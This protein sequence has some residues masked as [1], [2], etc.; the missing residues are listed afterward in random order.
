MTPNPTGPPTRDEFAA[1]LIKRLHQAGETRELRYDEA[2]FQLIYLE[3]GQV[4][5]RQRLVRMFDELHRTPIGERKDWWTSTVA[6]LQRIAD[7]LA[8]KHDKLLTELRPSIRPRSYFDNLVI[9]ADTDGLVGPAVPYLRQRAAGA[10][11]LFPTWFGNPR[12]RGGCRAR[13]TTSTSSSSVLDR[14]GVSRSCSRCQRSVHPAAVPAS[15]GS[16]A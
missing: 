1:F 4:V 8:G 13:P 11:C 7:D 14:I 15:G 16:S 3:E 10:C 12:S 5:E 9:Q 6:K 2:N